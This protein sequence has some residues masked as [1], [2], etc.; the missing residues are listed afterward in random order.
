MI[1]ITDVWSYNFDKFV[2]DVVTNII[3]VDVVIID[4]L[5]EV[6]YY[7]KVFIKDQIDKLFN[8]THQHNV[9]VKILTANLNKNKNLD[10]FSNIEIIHWPA[11][12]FRRTYGVWTSC[13]AVKFNL[14][15]GVD[16][17]E[18]NVCKNFELTLPYICLNNIRKNHRSKLMDMLAKN[19]LIKRGA[20]AWRS[21]CHANIPDHYPYKYWKPEVLLLDQGLDV[22]FRQETI[23]DEFN[24]TFMQLVTESDDIETFFSEKTATPIFLNKPFLVA[25]NS[26]F[27]RDLKSLGFELYDELFDYSFDDEPDMETRYDNLVQ[28]LKRY[29]GLNSVQLKDYYDKVS[30]KIT[31]NRNLAIKY[32]F[33]VP[34]E[35]MD[36]HLL[37][38]E[39]VQDYTGPLNNIKYIHTG[40]L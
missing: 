1:K 26:G 38:E 2:D 33:E 16:I 5:N 14:S 30:D 36:L 20:I 13:H 40:Q 39:K 23:P 34:K 32:A 35:I 6:D 25:T 3:D 12:W 28:N 17:R 22:K 9:P 29:I 24:H 15:K 19:D 21:V 4:C 37:V 27:H 10:R 11:Y 8:I 7:D 18:S 31:Y